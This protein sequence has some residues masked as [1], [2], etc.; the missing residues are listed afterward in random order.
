MK[1][2]VLIPTMYKNREYLNL[3]VESLLS[4]TDWDI[5]VCENGAP[6][7]NVPNFSNNERV[8]FMHDSRQGQCM[9]VNQLAVVAPVDTDY[10]FV[11]NDDMYYASGWNKALEFK[12]ACFS[13]NLIEPI[14]NAGSAPP[15]LK[16]D[17]GLI[18]E[19]FKQAVVDDFVSTHEEEHDTTGFN[20]PFFIHLDLWKTI[21]GYDE[22]Y[23]PWGSNSDT[24]LQTKIELAGVQPMRNRNMLVYH[25]GSK[26][27]TFEG[28][29]QEYWWR[30]WN[31][32]TDKW[33]FN[34][35]M[36]PLPDTWMAT[37]MVNKD[38]NIFHPNWEGSWTGKN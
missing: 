1:V 6:F 7:E 34:R 35:D 37:S 13:P 26:S 32:Y 19:E 22:K 31:Y 36:E 29:Q 18:I 27:G 14:D 10:I 8:G 28:P 4:T 20:L 17:G 3:C 5:I 23:D 2:V 21:G 12:Y 24:D 25:F 30:N 15:F 16:L 9:A 33:G 38:K 11:T